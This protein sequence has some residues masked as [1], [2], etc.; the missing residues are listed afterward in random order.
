MQAGDIFIFKRPCSPSYAIYF[1]RW[2]LPEPTAAPLLCLA[3]LHHL[4]YLTFMYFHNELFGASFIPPSG[5]SDQNLST[6]LSENSQCF[7]WVTQALS[8]ATVL[9][10]GSA[11]SFAAL[12]N[13]LKRLLSKLRCFCTA[14]DPQFRVG[15]WLPAPAIF[16]P[17]NINDTIHPVSPPRFSF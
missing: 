5:L 6:L 11:I 1:V 8:V 10:K 13:F 14:G 7:A 12:N 2:F 3:T 16:T 9:R 17:W 4:L 15:F